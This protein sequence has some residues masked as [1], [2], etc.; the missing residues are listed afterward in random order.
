MPGFFVTF[1]G[2]EGCGKTTQAELLKAELERDGYRVVSTREPGG[3]EV[4][5]R[6][7]QILLDY[8]VRGMEP[9]TEL[10]LYLAARAQ[11]VQEL[12]R[13]ALREGA[14]VIADR[15]A[16]ASLAYQGA[17]RQI[18]LSRVLDLNRIAT[19]GLV[20]DYTILLD[21]PVEAGMERKSAGHEG[22]SEHD[23]IEREELDFHSRV[24]EGYLTLARQFSDRIEVFDGTLDREELAKNI[25]ERLKRML[26]DRGFGP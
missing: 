1:E 19:F 8:H 23:R 12:I 9:L 11:N 16:D 18:G 5:E 25:S 7:R 24:R 10:F 26:K 13:P 3:T 22:A 2:V 20:P 14:I 15:F 21:V 6:I 4:G 17:G